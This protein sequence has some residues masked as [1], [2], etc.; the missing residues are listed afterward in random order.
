M[1][2]LINKIPFCN[3]ANEKSTLHSNIVLINDVNKISEKS[4]TFTLLIN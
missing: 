2:N 3:E 1:I 4:E